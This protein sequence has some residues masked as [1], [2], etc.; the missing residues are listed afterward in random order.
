[1]QRVSR[2]DTRCQAKK[3]KR[4]DSPVVQLQGDVAGS[5]CEIPADDASLALGGRRDGG[6]VEELARVVLY[7][8]QP[9]K[10]DLTEKESIS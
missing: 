8:R 9:D 2:Q 10:G 5:V 4:T 6:D 7:T 1:M 3:Q